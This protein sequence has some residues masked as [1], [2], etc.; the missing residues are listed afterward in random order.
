MAHEMSHVG[1]YDIRMMTMVA[2]VVGL[3][4]AGRRLA[5]ALH[6]V[7]R[8]VARIEQQDKGGGAIGLIILAIAIVFS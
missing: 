5:A 1:N 8:R 3:D 4:R 7:R 2:V 6:L